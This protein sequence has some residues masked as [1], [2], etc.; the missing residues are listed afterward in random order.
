MASFINAAPM[1]NDLGTKDVSTRVVPQGALGIP[2]HLP[3]L[4]IFAEKGPMGPTYVDLDTVSLT[5]LYGVNTFDVNGKYYTHQTPFLETIAAAGNNCVV[6]RVEGTGATDVANLALYLD[7][8]PTQVPLYQKATDGSLLLTAGGLPIPVLDAASAPMMV[9][10]YTVAWVVDKTIAP[11]GAY[12]RGLLTQRPGIQVAGATQSTQ[13]PLFEFAASSAGEYGNKLAV[14]LFAALASDL[15]PFPT[16]ILSD[17]KLYPYYFQLVSLADTITGKTVPVLN[18]FGSQSAKFV[19]MSKGIDP[20][21]GA[22]IDLDK[23]VFDQYIDLPP[24]QATGLGTAHVYNVGANNNMHTVLTMLYGAESVV[25]DTHRDAVI[26]TLENNLYAINLASFTSSNG[27]PYQS[28]KLVDIAGS[29]RLTKLTNLYLSGSSDGVMTEPLLDT[30]VAT[31]L[32]NYNNSLHEYNDLVIHPESIIYDS[33]FTLATKKAFPNFIARRKDTFVALSTY[34]HDAPSTT[35]ADQYS[36]G[37][38]LKTMIELFPESA[39][40]GTPVMRGIIMGGSGTLISSLYT[41]R[42]PTTYEIAYKSAAYMGAKSGAWKNGFAFDRA[43]LSIISQLKNID[44]TWVPAST[45]NTL[46][47]VGVNFALNY[48][49][50]SQFFPAIQTVYQNDTSVLNSYFTAI[51]ISYINKIEHA[52][53][54][55]F[56]GSISLTNAQLEEQV[57]NFVSAAVKDKFDAKF[58]IQPNAVVTALDNIRG[59]SWTLGVRIYANGLKSVMTTYVEAHRMT[60]LVV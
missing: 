57:N 32:N 34:A 16:T 38:A 47:S 53:W 13:Y 4:Y 28:I 14:R 5:K 37:I 27:S 45:R 30:L 11:I 20:A 19:S 58:V 60:D 55:E 6:H 33:G 56:S 26:N 7:V 50:N 48:K 1:V 15:Q 46:W 59:Y 43:P 24:A 18:S 36:V 52:A 8:L 29:T 2:Q 31:D 51:A 23:V 21:S 12:Q 42:V 40:F 10:G 35:L 3:K 17:G 22:V 9:P 44:V 49:I 25:V 39:T 54:R 41:K